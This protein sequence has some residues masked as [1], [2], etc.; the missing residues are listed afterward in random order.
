M[1]LARQTQF[2]VILP[3]A[4]ASDIS[5]QESVPLPERF[6]GGG[7][8]SLRAFGYNEAGPR[9]TGAPLGPGGPSSQPTGFPLG[10]NALF[11]NN[12]ELRFPFIGE[13]IQGVFFHD[14]GNVFSSLSNISFRFHQNNLQDFNY[15]VHAIGFGVRYKTPVGPIRLDLAY[16]INPP[17]FLGFGGTPTE[18]LQCNP[19]LPPSSLP[20]YC[21]STRQNSGHFQ[22]FFSIGQAF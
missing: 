12:V 6:F 11:F 14:M 4:V 7:A 13:N 17:S 19:S 1:V 16:S 9:D 15:T 2:G 5:A 21:Q 18:L 22:F 3:F 20:S 8:D 10:G